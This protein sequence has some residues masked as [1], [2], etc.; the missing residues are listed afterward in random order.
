ML[1]RNVS[2]NEVT[3][4][5]CLGLCGLELPLDAFGLQKRGLYGRKSRCKSCLS[6]TEANRRTSAPEAHL[7]YRREWARNNHSKV[8]LSRLKYEEQHP[9]RSVWGQGTPEQRLLTR[10]RHRA[11]VFK[12]PFSLSLEHIVIPE[13][14]PY[15]GVR[16]EI[17]VG[18]HVDASPSLDRIEPSLGYVPGN[19]EVISFRANRIKSD[20]T[21]DEHE[22]VARRMRLLANMR[23]D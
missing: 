20:G 21:V 3:A 10:A 2:H 16:L 18:G 9:G 13:V 22:K 5:K 7:A 12:I 23:T 6:T 14:C 17:G 1:Q 4:K 11:L 8:S 19:V 15:L